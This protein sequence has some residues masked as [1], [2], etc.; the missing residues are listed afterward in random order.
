MNRTKTLLLSLIS[1]M[2][3]QSIANKVLF[4]DSYHEGYPWSD[5]LTE[6][7]HIAIGNEAEIKIFRMDTKRFPGEA[8]ILKAASDAKALIE[9]W[10]PDVVIAADDNASKYIIEPHYKTG[11]L[12]IVFCGINWDCSVYGFPTDNICGMEE[13]GLVLPLIAQL[14]K[15]AKGERIGYL[16]CDNL[17]ARSEAENYKK[18]FSLQLEEAYVKTASDWQKAF[19]AM[20][21]KVDILILDNNAGL[22]DWDDATMKTF[23]ENHIKVPTGCILDW[24]TP[25]SLFGYTKLA[26]EQGEWAGQ[27]ALQIIKG[28]S[29][30]EIGVTQNKQGNLFVNPTLA[31]KLGVKIPLS[32][33]SKATLVK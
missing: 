15:Y 5:G 26:T 28:K 31:E 11:T 19:I 8:D 3:S 6:G 20:Q 22:A 7:V 21:D 12:P 10:K 33:L 25:Y 13:V 18:K 16:S 17:T 2:A 1:L 14:K 23:V 4:I 30:K 27:S 29:P 24:M 32:T 9:T